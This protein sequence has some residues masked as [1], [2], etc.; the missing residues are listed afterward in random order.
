MSSRF[1]VGAG[2]ALPMVMITFGVLWYYDGDRERGEPE[3]S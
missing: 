3:C 1:Q 2:E